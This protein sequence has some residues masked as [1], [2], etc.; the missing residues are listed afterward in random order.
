SAATDLVRHEEL[1]AAMTDDE[2]SRVVAAYVRQPIGKNTKDALA[3]AAAA[4]RSPAAA[5]AL[6]DSLL[7]PDAARI[8]G[9][10]GEAL[11]RME[12]PAA[13]TL[14]AARLSAATPEQQTCL[15]GALGTVGGAA[16]APKVAP[17]LEAT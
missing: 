14:L 4:T 9:A 10:V 1:H 8:R 5:Q 7:L 16:A 13:E 12:L 11:R 2:R 17:L 15:L 3:L 6:V